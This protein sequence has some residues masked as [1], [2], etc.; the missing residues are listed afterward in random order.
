MIKLVD[1]LEQS[2]REANIVKVPEE[3]LSKL[4]GIYDYTS[5]NLDKLKGIA[6]KSYNLPHIPASYN[7][8]L[9]FKDLS[10]NPIEVSIGYYN[11]PEDVAGGR[12][13]TR[14]DIMLINLAFFGDK[15]DFLDL[16]E[17]ELVHAM[18]PKVRDIKIYGK[19]YA[20]KGAEPVGADTSRYL[21]SP[22]EF[23]A[24][25]APLI[26]KLKA[27]LDKY[28]DKKNYSQSILQ[29]FSDLRTK[30]V[31]TVAEDEKYRPLAYFFTKRKVTK[32]DWPRVYAEFY[33]EL[34]KIK[35]WIT[36]PTLYKKFL[37]RLYTTIK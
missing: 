16:G 35:T 3:I 34:R 29:M 28:G 10:N 32:E 14:K 25:T 8:Y 12:M 2:L 13:D 20:K 21:K 4:E 15:E 22:W 7:K 26:N 1:I 33:D 6:S 27:N 36:K 11:D 18:D 5:K 19:I 31:N 23:D 24:F 9:K 17:H 37:Q 30:D